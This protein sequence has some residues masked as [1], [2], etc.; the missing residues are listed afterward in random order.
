MFKDIFYLKGRN[1]ESIQSQNENKDLFLRRN[2]A[3]TIRCGP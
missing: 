1:R 3:N 2:T